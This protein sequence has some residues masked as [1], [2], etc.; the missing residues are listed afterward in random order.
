MVSPDTEPQPE[1]IEFLL[2]LGSALHTS[3]SSANDLE[4]TIAAIA[5]KWELPSPQVFSTPTSLQVAFGPLGQQRVYVLRVEPGGLNLG[6]LS[7]LDEIAADM[8]HG[9][10]T[11]SEGLRML[12]TKTTARAMYQPWMVIGAFALASGSFACIL[13]GGASEV[14]A[15]VFIGA[16]T[17]AIALVAERLARVQ[18]VFEP[19]A[20]FVA[21][22]LATAIAAR[23][24]PLASDLVTLAGLIMLIPG[25][26]LTSGLQDLSMRHLTTGAAHLSLALMTFLG[27]VFGVALGNAVSTLWIGPAH[28]VPPGLLPGW[29]LAFAVVIASLS[30]TVTMHVRPRD[31][32]WVLLAGIVAVATSRIGTAA[33]GPLGAV[34]GGLSVGLIS[35]LFAHWRDRPSA[36][37]LVPGLVMLVPGSVGYKSLTAF[38]HADTASGVALAAQMFLIGVALVYGLLLANLITGP[39]RLLDLPERAI[40]R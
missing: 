2:R 4:H 29:A 18:R 32:G 25:L 21:G 6:L 23:V 30:F 10:L 38:L 11:P 5:R 7:A 22:F 8:L 39:R 40:Q 31:V 27:I 3:G 12:A 36:I 20:S 33:L 14:I 34:I 17:G 19:L 35:N 1:E 37:M 13:G 16:I 24:V 28:I 15:A 26:T 9:K